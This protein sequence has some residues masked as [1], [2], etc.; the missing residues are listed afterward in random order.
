MM[1][2]FTALRTLNST[3]GFQNVSVS[4]LYSCVIIAFASI[5]VITLLPQRLAKVETAKLEADLAIKKSFV[6]YIS[7][8]L[9][10]PLSIA[11][12]GLDLLNEQ[13]NDGAPIEELVAMIKDIKS[14]CLSGVAI[15][16]NLLDFEKLDSGLTVL[17]ATDQDPGVFFESTVAPFKLVARQKQIELIV[18]NSLA[19]TAN[20]EAVRIDASKMSQVL[21]NLLSNAIKFTQVEGTVTVTASVVDE[22]FTVKVEDTGV[23]ISA[24]NQ[25]RLFGEGVQ[26]H[27]NA[28]QGTSSSGLGLWISKK[29]V[30]LHGGTIGVISEGNGKGSTF[31]FKLPLNTTEI[32]LTPIEEAISRAM[33]S[34]RVSVRVAPSLTNSL[35]HTRPIS[36][37]LPTNLSIL[38]VDDSA[39][40]RKMMI[41]RLERH[42][43]TI[44]EADDGDVA[45]EMVQSS[46]RGDRPSFDVIS[47]DNVMP[48]MR[49][50]EAAQKIRNIGYKGVIVG[51]TGNVL[52]DDVD[53]FIDHG[54]NAVLPKPFELDIFIHKVVELLEHARRTAQE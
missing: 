17:E 40:N 43:C 41:K 28:H 12:S 10:T 3:N 27:T 31:Y 19:G 33:S 45:L 53:E 14:P 8:E 11:I 35:L 5:I 34:R 52:A 51:I 2:L 30:E 15:L 47:M 32:R 50:P 16:N 24:E 22:A 49:G 13:L 4:Y 6:R 48:R 37:R 7:H 38:I 42:S 20:R 36:V 54:V 1:V 25:Q 39:L 21:C 18:V 26:F 44:A 29:I 23:G 46:L 9:R